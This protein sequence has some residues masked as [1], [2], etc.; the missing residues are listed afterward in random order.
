MDLIIIIIVYSQFKFPLWMC[1]RCDMTIV[2]GFAIIN[3]LKYHLNIYSDEVLRHCGSATVKGALDEDE[4]ETSHGATPLELGATDVRKSIWILSRLKLDRNLIWS[5]E[6]QFEQQVETRLPL[7][8]LKSCSLRAVQGGVWTALWIW[9]KT[10]ETQC[11][12]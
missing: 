11:S 9:R 5:L 7:F 1:C 3:G 6:Q 2:T 4:D 12:T 8:G 10:L